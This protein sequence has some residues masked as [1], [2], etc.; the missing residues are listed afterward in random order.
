MSIILSEGDKGDFGLIFEF[1]DQPA[2]SEKISVLGGILF[3]EEQ[4]GLIEEFA[5]VFGLG[6]EFGYQHNFGV[7]SFIFIKDYYKIEGAK[8]NKMR[9]KNVIID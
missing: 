9:R 4:P 7:I 5:F 1:V 6:L 2:D 8:K 3:D